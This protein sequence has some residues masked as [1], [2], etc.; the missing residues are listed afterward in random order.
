MFIKSATILLVACPLI[1]AH[2]SAQQGQPRIEAGSAANQV[3]M[4]Q[5]L[6]ADEF[7]QVLV[8]A[9]ENL[10]IA[11]Q[12]TEQGLRY[13]EAQGVDT[14]I[15]LRTRPEMDDRNMVPFDQAALLA[16]LGIH[17][18][19]IPAGGEDSPYSAAMVTQFA[20]ALANARGKVLLH[21]TVAWRA[22]HLYTAYLYRHAGLSLT[23]AV[24]HGRAINLGQLPV[25]GFLGQE[26][27]LRLVEPVDDE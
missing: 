8:Q 12:P 22:S 17:Y 15:N 25:E 20:Q 10:F 19:H 16:T 6:P 23:E 5:R 21:C 24:R 4:P 9:G 7:N 2:A 1:V 26:V 13:L 11:G 18:V 3:T 14:V 27:S